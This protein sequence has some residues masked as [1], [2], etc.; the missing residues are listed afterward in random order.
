[1]SIKYI[2]LGYLSWRPMT[3]YDVK[4]IIAN[5]ETL[6]WTANNNQIYR[7]LVQMHKDGWV[8]KEIED[9]IG[10]PNRHVYSITAVGHQ[11]LRK[12]TLSMPEAPHT[13]K[14]FLYQLMWADC[15]SLDEI[16]NLLGN[17]LNAVGE[18]LFFIRVQADEKPSMPER[19]PRESYL[20]NMISKNMIAQYEVELNWIRLLRQEL[21]ELDAKGK[22][23]HP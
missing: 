23:T 1:M 9:Q 20:W 18:K 19:S 8:T 11:A 7:A 6:P 14:S 13:K 10:S 3:G 16:D 12:W 5:S 22:R 15:L 21:S 2:I 4:K 17:Y